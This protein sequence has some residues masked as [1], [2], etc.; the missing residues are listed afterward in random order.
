[1]LTLMVVKEADWNNTL[2][3]VVVS[4]IFYFHPYLRK[5][6]HFDQHVFQMGWNHQLVSKIECIPSVKLTEP[7]E[8]QCGCKKET[9]YFPFEK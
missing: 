4:N 6:I 9:I 1:M 3:W 5:M 2:N 7:L 8:N